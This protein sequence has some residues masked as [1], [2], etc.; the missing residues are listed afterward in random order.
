MKRFTV[1]F[2]ALAVLLVGFGT[3][4]CNSK[5]KLAEQQRKE[6]EAKK[7]EKAKTD[8][9]AILNDNTKTAAEKEKALNAIKAL[10]IQDPEVKDLISKVEQKITDQ[11][12]VEAKKR[13]EDERLRKEAEDKKKDQQKAMSLLDYMN[14]IAGAGSPDEANKMIGDALKLFASPDAQVLIVVAKDGTNKADWDYDKPTTIKQ[15][16]NYIKDQKKFDKKIESMD[17]DASG[18]IKLL[19]LSK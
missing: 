12:V 19:E 6:A 10:N 18:K 11:K 16:L 3:S 17:K 5:K 15:Y 1:L 4:S 14:S 13:E 2:F 9:L 8:L 7:V